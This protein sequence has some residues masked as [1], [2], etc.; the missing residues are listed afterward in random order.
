MRRTR[1]FY[2]QL[3]LFGICVIFIGFGLK[4]YLKKRREY[5][6]L[7]VEAS[8][9]IASEAEAKKNF[10]TLEK[11][12][13]KKLCESL[14]LPGSGVA[15]F[16][17]SPEERKKVLALF[18]DSK[19]LLIQWLGTHPLQ[20]SQETL[21]AMVERV[22]NLKVVIPP[23]NEEPD[24]KWRGIG[25]HTQEGPNQEFL[26][27]GNGFIKL[28]L[29]NPVRAQ[30]E[31]T[32]LLAQAWA[33]CEFMNEKVNPWSGLLRCLG[34]EEQV[35]NEWTYS[36]AGWAV[37]SVLAAHLSPPGCELPMM[38]KKRKCLDPLLGDGGKV[39]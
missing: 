9:K 29:D 1:D 18:H 19:R 11:Q 25:V 6:S 16:H 32:R 17:V 36:E 35:C 3:L 2:K 39:Q 8:R 34:L 20:T 24:L 4:A 10:E 37:S 26:R 38:A 28:T 21:G 33:P 14:E 31:L 22:A 23:S 7:K 12:K 30:F 5:A 27:L 13:I 15:P